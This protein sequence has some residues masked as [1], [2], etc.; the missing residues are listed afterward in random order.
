MYFYPCMIMQFFFPVY[1]YILLNGSICRQVNTGEDT[2]SNSK[3]TPICIHTHMHT[4]DTILTTSCALTMPHLFLPVG[5]LL[6]PHYT[7][8]RLYSSREIVAHAHF[9]GFFKWLIGNVNIGAW[10]SDFQPVA[11]IISWMQ[12]KRLRL[13]WLAIQPWHYV[14]GLILVMD[15]G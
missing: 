1:E 7:A 2:H 4:H 13:L 9:G 5:I 10:Y 14:T 3:C 6:V 12:G 8:L 15:G 11:S